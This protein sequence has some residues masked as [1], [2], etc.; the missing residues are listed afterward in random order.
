MALCKLNDIFMLKKSIYILLLFFCVMSQVYAA[1]IQY[2]ITGIQDDLRENAQKRLAVLQEKSPQL[3]SATF[4]KKAVREIKLALEPY[5]YFY[6][7]VNSYIIKKNNETKVIFNVTPGI[8]L[9]ITDIKV[10]LTGDGHGNPALKKFLEKFPLQKG[11]QFNAE[12]YEKTKQAFFNVLL[13]RGYL[14]PVFIEQKIL[15]DL[16]KHHCTIIFVLDT[17]PLFYFGP[18]AFSSSPL[19]INF[20]QRYVPF[21]SGERYSSE[22]ISTLQRNL[23]QSGYFKYAAVSP[24]VNPTESHSVP[25]KINI[26]MQKKQHTDV[27]IGFG[28][29][30]GVRISAKNQWRYLNSKGHKFMTGI[31]LS[32]VQKSLEASYIIPGENPVTDQYNLNA[33]LTTTN[34]T[35]GSSRIE[36]V[37]VSKIKSFE[38][39]WQQ[40]LSLN[41][42][43][44]QFKFENQPEQTSRLLIPGLL[45][46]YL[47]SNDTIFPTEGN[48]FSVNIRGSF[49]NPLSSN[50]FWQTEI[51]DKFIHHFTDNDRLILRG[52]IGYTNV[53]E[54]T[55]FPL[56]LRYYAGGAQ[57]IR[58]FSYQSLGPGKY[59]LTSSIE[60]QQRL[61]GEWYGAVFAD[62][63]NASNCLSASLERSA[64]VGIVWKSPVGVMELTFAR[65]ISLPGHPFRLQFVLGPDL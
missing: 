59:L 9:L 40:S 31:M 30:T 43:M 53:K 16:K 22:K 19:S 7:V 34:I 36:Q 61:H 45:W 44:E 28:T 54:L 20:L 64:G 42:Q 1:S 65:V 47:K 46:S 27:G 41:E 2:D 49:R 11:E 21:Q 32:S 3:N 60:W 4:I 56:S 13:Q 51:Q 14:T 29:D 55:T 17:G 24:E 35:S 26:L 39:N 5:G 23:N 10:T 38:N 15:I 62:A 48:R 8:A 58:G 37:G 50:A 25:V 12:K 6:G 52:D 63:G 57:S 18:V 33:S